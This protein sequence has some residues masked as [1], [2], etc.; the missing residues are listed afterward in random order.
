[1]NCHP[2]VGTGSDETLKQRWIVRQTRTHDRGWAW[3]QA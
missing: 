3:Q 2:Q 1:V